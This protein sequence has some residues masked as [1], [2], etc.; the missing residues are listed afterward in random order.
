MNIYSKRE[1]DS[2]SGEEP[3]ETST[4][5]PRTAPEAPTGEER[6]SVAR[7]PRRWNDRLAFSVRET[8]E[9]LGVSEKTVR[10]LIDRRL[11]RVSRALRHILIPKIAITEFLE[12][13]SSK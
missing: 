6:P 7:D 13:T 9:I 2:V 1:S 8:A 10:R 5:S 3:T 4:L 11:L 12:Q